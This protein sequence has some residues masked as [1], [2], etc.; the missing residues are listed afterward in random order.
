MDVHKERRRVL[1]G[2]GPRHHLGKELPGLFV[3]H[4]EP[5]SGMGF[6]VAT[7][8]S[9]SLIEAM[10]GSSPPSSSSIGAAGRR[11]WACMLPGAGSAVVEGAT[12][13]VLGLR[14]RLPGSLAAASSAC[15][16]AIVSS[17]VSR[18]TSVGGAA[19]GAGV[20]SAGEVGFG[21]SFSGAAVAGW[22]W[23]WVAAPLAGDRGAAP[24]A[25]DRGAAAG[26]SGEVWG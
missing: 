18:G 3:G 10:A 15:S 12:G 26:W 7:R 11:P 17:A 9:R 5:P 24:L 22:K 16:R 4:P 14:G 21:A 13:W 25:G 1:T 6:Y 8:L 23:P 20:G 19:A 2:V